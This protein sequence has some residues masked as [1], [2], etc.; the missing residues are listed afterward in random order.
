MMRGLRAA[1]TVITV[2]LV[3]T[4]LPVAAVPVAAQA[5][6]RSGRPSLGLES[7]AGSKIFGKVVV[8]ETNM[9]AAT[10]RV[11]VLLA[12]RTIAESSVRNDGRFIISV[13]R[14]SSGRFVIAIDGGARFGSGF[15]RKNGRLTPT[16]AQA[17]R[18]GVGNVGEVEVPARFI[19]GTVVSSYSSSAIAG[20]VVSARYVSAPSRVIRSTTTGANGTFSLPWPSTAPRVALY[21]DG[22]AVGRESGW[23]SCGGKLEERW[24][25]VE[26]DTTPG[27]IGWIWLDWLDDD[28]DD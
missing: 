8:G 9:P 25:D 22:S 4:A 23:R 27:P 16:L 13:P 5:S 24:R 7:L 15:L 26:C 11:R 14:A 28:E 6:E 17:G 1:M 12:N 10:A 18:F 2:A 20:V 3:T 21:V 19:S